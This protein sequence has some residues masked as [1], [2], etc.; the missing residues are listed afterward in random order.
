MIEACLRCKDEYGLSIKRGRERG[1]FNEI[2][3]E[4]KQDQ[5]ERGLRKGKLRISVGDL[6][7]D[8]E[9]ERNTCL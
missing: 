3:R 1:Q 7:S 9:G 5:R 2:E 4:V 6:R 8:R